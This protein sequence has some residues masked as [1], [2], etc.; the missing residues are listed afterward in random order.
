MAQSTAEKKARFA[1]VAVPRVVTAVD[2]FRKL[3]NCSVPSQYEWDTIRWKKVFV[4]ILVAVQDCAERFDLKVSFTIN[5]LSSED[6][7][8][9]EAIEEYLS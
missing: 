9:P 6:L 1:R 8:D 2:L 5:G 3:G 7:Y 4:H